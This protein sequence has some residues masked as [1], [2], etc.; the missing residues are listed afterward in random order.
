M[1]LAQACNRAQLAP[2][3]LS[4][5]KRLQCAGSNVLTAKVSKH[6]K[7][8]PQ[9]A[10]PCKRHSH[11]SL[12]RALSRI[13]QWAWS[14]NRAC[15]QE[16]KPPKDAKQQKPKKISSCRKDRRLSLSTC[17]NTL[18]WTAKT[19]C[20]KSTGL[21]PTGATGGKAKLLGPPKTFPPAVRACARRPSLH[22][23]E[24]PRTGLSA[25][26]SGVPCPARRD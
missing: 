1:A 13:T 25:T 20:L 15:G 23:F 5:S 2:A 21:L 16:K 18:E 22:L 26:T 11:H 6:A 17:Q 3:V 7:S 10:A 12:S 9:L 4:T 24:T 19:F 8:L 14:T